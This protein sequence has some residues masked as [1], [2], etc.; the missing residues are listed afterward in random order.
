M[1]E[2][3]IDIAG[4]TTMNGDSR[5]FRNTDKGSL[6]ENEVWIAGGSGGRIA[7]GWRK[8]VADCQ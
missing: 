7:E 4:L 3:A 8:G 5:P 1:S 6:R 2:G